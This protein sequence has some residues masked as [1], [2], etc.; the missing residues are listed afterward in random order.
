MTPLSKFLASSELAEKIAN[1]QDDDAHTFTLDGEVYP[2][3]SQVDP[4]V[5]REK[6][7]KADIPLHE[8][9]LIS[10][11][12]ELQNHAHPNSPYTLRCD[13]LT[14]FAQYG[15]DAMLPYH[16]LENL[17]GNSSMVLEQT[18]DGPGMWVFGFVL[19]GEFSIHGIVDLEW[20]NA[21]HRFPMVA[22]LVKTGNE[23]KF[24]VLLEK[25][26]QALSITDGPVRIELIE[27]LNYRYY[28]VAEVDTS[29]FDP[30]LPIDIFALSGHGSYWENQ[31]RLI[32]GESIIPPAQATQ[33]VS[34][35]WLFSRSG[36]VEDI[37]GVDNALEMPGVTNVELQVETGSRLGHIR[38]IESRDEIGYVVVTGK[39][40]EQAQ[41]NA[42]VV[43]KSIDIRRKTVL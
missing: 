26:V 31:V 4:V 10:S 8:Y 7:K 11:E 9:I 3:Q 13:S 35:Q 16:Q 28:T 27:N 30:A 43:R 34:L 5:T 20:L 40:V 32:Q 39:S 1:T 21:I 38:H 19:N 24:D 36:I 33:A 2:F 42:A 37:I 12:C 25:V 17:T 18:L 22:N 6:L 41:Q 29:W 14:R 15:A 23:E